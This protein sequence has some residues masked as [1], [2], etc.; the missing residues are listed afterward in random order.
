MAD[1]ALIGGGYWGKNLARNFLQLGA[2]H[3]VCDVSEETLA[4]YNSEYIAVK[5]SN[6]IESVLNDPEITK[7]AIATPALTHF[8]IAHSALIAGKDVYV[9]KPLC[10]DTSEA[11]ELIRLARTSGRILMV[12]HLLQYHPHVEKL[13]EL[14][15][16]GQ[17]GRLHYITSNR[18]NLGKV[19]QE[20]NAL[21]SFAPHDVS[22]ILGLAGG[23]PEEVVCHGASYLT[24]GIADTTLTQLKFASG[25]RAHVYVSWL[26]PF[27]EQKLTVVGSNGMAVFDDTKS[28]DEK[29]IL[30]RDYLTWTEGNFPN[31]KK[32]HGEPIIVPQTEPLQ[33]ECAHFL[34]VCSDRNRPKTDGA[35]G[36]RVLQVLKAAQ[37]SLDNNGRGID[38]INVNSKKDYFAHAT[39]VIDP[40]ANIGAGTK[41]WHFSHVSDNAELGEN[42]NIGQNVFVASG[43]KIGSNV[44]IQNNVSVYSGTT[45][46]DN[47]FLGPSCVLTNVINPRSEVN[48]RGMYEVTHIKRGATVGANA[49]IV[50]GTTLGCYCFVG[51]GAV[52][53]KDIPD[54]ALV[55]GVPARVAG[56]ISR[57]GEKLVF[58]Q[59]GIAVCSA[60]QERYAAITD[61][62]Q[63]VGV[64]HLS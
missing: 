6:N 46:D 8:N 64:S 20:E 15:H 63:I 22:V 37:K 23:L 51:A 24:I 10:V 59:N 39:A 33:N 17:L 25:L 12:G 54:Y 34:S 29:L 60:T 50:C 1:L 9:E 58:D 5:R 62:N 30:F 36:L 40:H 42:C 32:Q 49:T 61:Q 41:V 35:E 19:R 43:V 27:K 13:I 44:K 26:N 55:V 38:P 4:S 16:E 18:L 11:E 21:W 28:W 3:T 57:F 53:T 7:V 47:V 14:V 48:R 52:V 2:L 31:V 45:I 56:W